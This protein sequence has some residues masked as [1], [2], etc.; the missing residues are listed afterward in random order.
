MCSYFTDKVTLM[1]LGRALREAPE[2]RREVGAPGLSQARAASATRVHSQRN[3]ARAPALEGC[4]ERF[5]ADG[6]C[7]RLVM[8]HVKVP[9][10]V[11][12]AEAS[13]RKAASL[14]L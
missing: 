9:L 11:E 2:T 13:E 4:D 10:D 5:G 14:K 6:Q 3:R 8:D 7:S 1:R 12:A